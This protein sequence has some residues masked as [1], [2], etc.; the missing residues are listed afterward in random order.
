VVRAGALFVRAV[1]A[2]SGGL[3]FT[4]SLEHIDEAMEIITR[5]RLDQ[6]HIDHP[7]VA[8]LPGVAAMFRNDDAGA[9]AWARKLYDHPDPWARAMAHSLAGGLLI[10][11]GEVGQAE[12]EFGLGLAGF[13]ELGERWGVG[14]VLVELA[15]LS[16]ARGQHDAAVAALQE[17]REVFDGLGDREDVGQLMVRLARER[18]RAGELDQALRDLEEAGRIAREVGA[19]D[20]RLFIRQGFAEVAR[21]QGRLDEAREL[22]DGVVAELRRGQDP[23]GQRVAMALTG[24]GHVD[25]AAG[26]LDGA[27]EWYRRALQAA[28]ES[29]DRPVIARVVEL[30]AAIA[31]AQDDAGRAATLLGTAELLRGMPDEAD[32]DVARVRGAA[33]AML[34]DQGFARAH[35]RGAARPR[36]QVLAELSEEVRS[37]A[38]TPAGPAGRTPGR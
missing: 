8:M 23:I 7:M 12:A 6:P 1:I 25:V 9:L 4:R 5:S 11:L 37:A 16:A 24:R 22:H 3:D 34:G 10:N 14:Q 29:R 36:E 30:L 19:E 17:A 33:R 20:Q 28:V 18:V 32:R 13:R 27:H 35:R 38:G 2:I 21:W 31:L 15:D 26:D